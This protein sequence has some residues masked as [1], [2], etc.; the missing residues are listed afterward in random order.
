MSEIPTPLNE[1]HNTK[2]QSLEEI[3]VPEN[4]G[5]NIERKEEQNEVSTDDLI[6]LEKVKDQIEG[7]DLWKIKEFS[8]VSDIIQATNQMEALLESEQVKVIRESKKS[9]WRKTW[10]KLVIGATV[11]IGGGV[12]TNEGIKHYKYEK[13]QSAIEK[14]IG[15]DLRTVAEKFGFRTKLQVDNGGERHIFH[16]GQIHELADIK[17]DLLE[18][19]V[20]ENSRDRLIDYQKKIEKLIIKLQ[21]DGLGKKVYVEGVSKESEKYYQEIERVKKGMRF[22]ENFDDDILT[23]ILY[24]LAKALDEQDSIRFVEKRGK[25]MLN[26]PKNYL[27]LLKVEEIEEKL[28][29]NQPKFSQ[30]KNNK[31]LDQREKNA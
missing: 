28:K 7:L 30:E 22:K 15:F 12:A 26:I 20:A 5:E 3:V 16:I 19:V 1:N 11:L 6:E 2:E 31:I 24:I 23:G 4:Q 10:G 25:G 13:E 9:W 17:G 27:Y 14:N 18:H 8:G 29:N 21:D